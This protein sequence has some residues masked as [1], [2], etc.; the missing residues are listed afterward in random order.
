MLDFCAQVV[1]IYMGVTYGAVINIDSLRVR[2]IMGLDGKFGKLGRNTRDGGA[3]ARVS[4]WVKPINT[5]G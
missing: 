1:I 3:D 4:G 5:A 2:Y